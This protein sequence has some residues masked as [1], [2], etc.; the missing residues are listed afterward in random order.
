MGFAG[1]KVTFWI[2]KPSFP[3]SVA[4]PFAFTFVEDEMV[5]NGSATGPDGTVTEL[6]GGVINGSNV[7][8]EVQV[9]LGVESDRK[10][11]V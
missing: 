6:F 7:R 1:F 11:V 4:V 10:I 2:S 9:N 8:F 3:L 5:L